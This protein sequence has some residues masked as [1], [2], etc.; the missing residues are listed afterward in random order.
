MPPAMIFARTSEF[1]LVLLGAP[2]IAMRPASVDTH[3]MVIC[4]SANVKP[5]VGSVM[6][7]RNVIGPAPLVC[8][9]VALGVAALGLKKP[10]PP[11]TTD[12]TPVPDAGVFPPRPKVVPLVQMLCVGPTVATW[13]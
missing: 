2:R 9:N 5:Q 3:G 11:L 12:Q 1:Q 7:Q 10:V 13:T 4:T 8:V 6:V